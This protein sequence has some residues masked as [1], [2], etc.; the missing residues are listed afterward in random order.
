[1]G[2]RYMILKALS[3]IK[4]DDSYV[5]V[6]Q[7]KNEELTGLLKIIPHIAAGKMSIWQAAQLLQNFSL[8]LP[9]AMTHTC[10]HMHPCTNTH[11]S[12]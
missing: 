10:T 6:F 1:M 3:S 12:Y 8:F 9:L 2:L 4:L 11:V 7:F 5:S